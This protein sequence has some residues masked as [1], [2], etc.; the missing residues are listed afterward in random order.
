MNTDVVKLKD[1]F[2][3]PTWPV[4]PLFQRPYADVVDEVS[5]GD[6]EPEVHNFGSEDDAA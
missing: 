3:N 6:D 5:D 4:E 2:D 1:V